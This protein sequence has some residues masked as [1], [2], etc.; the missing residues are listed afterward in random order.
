[1]LLVTP[2][3][4][5]SRKPV[6]AKPQT[7][8]AIGLMSGTSQDGVDVA[9]LDTDGAIVGRCGATAFRSYTAEEHTLLRR[10]TAVASNLADLDARPGLVAEAETLGIGPGENR[11][12]VTCLQ[13]QTG[14]ATV[15]TSSYLYGHEHDRFDQGC[16]EQ[17][18][19]TRS[20]G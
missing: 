14:L 7:A 13:V 18:D 9:L 3:E 10:A 5:Q 6:T 11:N 20:P 16:Q 4:Q 12:S 15:A 19:G 17:A 8:L 2:E 1:M